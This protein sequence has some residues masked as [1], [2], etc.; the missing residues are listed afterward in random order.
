MLDYL[1]YFFAAVGVLTSVSWIIL[2]W[3]VMDELKSLEDVNPVIDL[4][5]LK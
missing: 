4:D 3:I 2:Y 5:D 1:L